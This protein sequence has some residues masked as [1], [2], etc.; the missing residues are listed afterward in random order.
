MKLTLALIMGHILASAAFVSPP[1]L[2]S[3]QL[4]RSG[5][6][7]ESDGEGSNP[8]KAAVTA[9]ASGEMSKANF[10]ALVC[11]PSP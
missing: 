4:S 9:F 2:L 8:L 11:F 6:Y 10:E 3:P 5:L 7:A 1:S